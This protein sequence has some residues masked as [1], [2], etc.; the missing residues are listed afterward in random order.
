[1]PGR[2]GPLRIL[3]LAGANARTGLG[4]LMRTA[5]RLVDGLGARRFDSR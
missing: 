2:K 4:H 5:R 1:M 3:V